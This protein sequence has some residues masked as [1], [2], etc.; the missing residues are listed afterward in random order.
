MCQ[1]RECIGGWSWVW[2]VKLHASGTKCGFHFM[3][4]ADTDIS[5][6]LWCPY[7]FRLTIKLPIVK[8][9]IVPAQSRYS[10]TNIHWIIC[11]IK[12]RRVS[13]GSIDQRMQFPISIWKEVVFRKIKFCFFIYDI[14]IAVSKAALILFL[15]CLKMYLYSTLYKILVC[16]YCKCFHVKVSSLL[17]QPPNWRHNCG[18]S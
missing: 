14:M 8:L 11:I 15:I 1:T 5:A 18:S 7:A 9:Q 3:A 16:L 17:T 2:S 4:R 6:F 13:T 12:S 10:N